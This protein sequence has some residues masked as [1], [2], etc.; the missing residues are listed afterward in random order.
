MGS[1]ENFSQ[2]VNGEPKGC[3][4]FGFNV[5]KILMKLV[6]K[7]YT[8]KELKKISFII[9]RFVESCGVFGRIPYACTNI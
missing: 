7:K 9:I 5:T 6:N 2:R 1:Q 4:K 8:C 3:G